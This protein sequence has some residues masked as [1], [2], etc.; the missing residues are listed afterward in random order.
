MPAPE[1]YGGSTAGERASAPVAVA[2]AQLCLGLV[3]IAGLRVDVVRPRELVT[4]LI[5]LTLARMPPPVVRPAPRLR[6]VPQSHAQ[7][8]APAR[9]APRPGGSPGPAP[10]HAAAPTATLAFHA[11]PAAPAGGGT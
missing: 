6:P 5:S 4:R 2:G 8:R 11:P 3:L 1:R 7:H 9:V 10:P